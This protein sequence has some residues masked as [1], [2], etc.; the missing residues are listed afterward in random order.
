MVPYQYQK[1][2]IVMYLVHLEAL[3]TEPLEV[4]T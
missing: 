2:A 4:I 3:K 1:V